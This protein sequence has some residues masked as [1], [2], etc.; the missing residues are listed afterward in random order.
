MP[1]KVE[2]VQ[3]VLDYLDKNG[4]VKTSDILDFISKQNDFYEDV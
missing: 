4:D 3:I 1:R 2:R